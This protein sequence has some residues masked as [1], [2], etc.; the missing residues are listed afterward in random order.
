MTGFILASRSTILLESPPPSLRCLKVV[1]A[2]KSRASLRAYPAA[3][4]SGQHTAP[5]AILTPRDLP[6]VLISGSRVIHRPAQVSD[7]AQARSDKSPTV[8][9]GKWW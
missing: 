3:R 4:F 9:L 7:F 1:I 6:G 2:A 5:S 8:A